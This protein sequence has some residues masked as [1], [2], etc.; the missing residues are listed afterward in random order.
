MSP[1][2]KEQQEEI[3][4]RYQGGESAESLSAAFGRTKSTIHRVIKRCGAIN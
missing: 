2:T 4:T 3:I 1:L